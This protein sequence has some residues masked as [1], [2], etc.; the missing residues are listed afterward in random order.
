LLYTAAK[1]KASIKNTIMPNTID[2]VTP[3]RGAK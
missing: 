1:M 2:F 3:I